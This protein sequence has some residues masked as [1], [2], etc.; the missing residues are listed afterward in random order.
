MLLPKPLTRGTLLQRYKRFLADVRLDSGEIITVHCPNSGSMKGCAVPGS[1]VLLSRSDNAGRKYAFTWELVR[2]ADAWVGINTALP[3]RLVREGV[4]CGIV[5]ELQGYQSIRPEV[6]YGANSRIDLLLS[7]Q[8]ELCY[9]E[10]K[11]VT[12]V[13]N[14][15]ASFPDAATIRGQ[16]HLRELMEMVRQ[17]HRAVNFFV[18]QHA[19]G[20]SVSPADA[21]D[22]EYGRLLRQ[23][24]A[25]GVE[26]LAYR[27]RITETEIMLAHRLPVVL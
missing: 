23:A 13:E 4:E 27:A 3:N 21:I 25:C 17:G 18:V 8:G 11:N 16:K 15:L 1:S 19:E 5:A 7:R 12:L 20:N 2:V 9:V 26:I 10:V 22:P 14:N 24:A 6:R